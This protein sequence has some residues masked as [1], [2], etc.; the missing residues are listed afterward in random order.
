M[1]IKPGCCCASGGGGGSSLDRVAPTVVVGNV[2]AGD[3][4]VA[5]S[6]DGFEYTPDTGNG[7]GIA[8]AIALLGPDGGRVYIRRG[9]Y[10]FN[11]GG[12]P[13][14]PLAVPANVTM[15]GEGVGSTVITGLAIG[16]QGVF[17][18]GASC[19]VL[20][21]TL[22]SD[23]ADVSAIGSSG[24]VQTA[25]GAVLRNLA[26][27]VAAAATGA[28]R[29]AV[30]VTAG[31]SATPV[32]MD[33]VVVT[34]ATKTGSA[35]PTVGVR[36]VGGAYVEMTN[37]TFTGGDVAISADRSY[38]KASN[39]EATDFAVSAVLRT[40]S[41]FA[42]TASGE[43]SLSNFRF[44]ADATGGA[45]VIDATWGGVQI[46]NGAISTS[47]ATALNAGIRFSEPSENYPDGMSI[48]NVSV[49][50]GVW[51]ALF[52]Y[53]G[54]VQI[55][56]LRVTP[57]TTGG[58]A[59]GGVRAFS[60]GNVAIDALSVGF[61]R[62]TGY[63]VDVQTSSNVR[64]NN[65]S[66]LLYGAAGAYGVRFRGVGD[67]HVHGTLFYSY[68]PNGGN[69]IVIEQPS[70]SV[71]GCRLVSLDN[72]A[73]AQV[74]VIDAT[75]VVISNNILTASSRNFGKIYLENSSSCV[76]NGN[77][78]Q[79]AVG[80]PGIVLD[81]T[82]TFNNVV[83]NYCQGSTNGGVNPAVTDNGTDNNVQANHGS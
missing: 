19:Q 51:G 44:V 63:G 9:E 45:N 8:A 69:L 35:A 61:V 52:E 5:Y 47:G 81:A 68:A 17:S 76:V 27:T 46:V 25:T 2:P 6:S 72:S 14:G 13:A 49:E 75:N 83:G 78:V 56:G 20:D 71:Q 24:V 50:N 10:D 54:N 59:A 48:A 38:V 15:Q 12:G 29:A 43:F 73:V 64:I 4:A 57:T 66:I 3:S 22:V 80:Q 28:M 37:C 11:A 53:V 34:A 70:V 41:T 77:N 16:N 32:V 39:I 21:M 1:T 23:T 30:S 58:V 26:I 65:S 60:S 18:L 82:S 7:A 55:T 79:S 33:A 36:A 62:G 42:S 67:C 74:R 40:N 31:A